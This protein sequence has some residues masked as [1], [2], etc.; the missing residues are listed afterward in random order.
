[1]AGAS[2]SYPYTADGFSDGA[3][4]PAIADAANVAGGS[5]WSQA[6]AGWDDCRWRID[7]DQCYRSNRSPDS[8]IT[9]TLTPTTSVDAVTLHPGLTQGSDHQQHQS[10]FQASASVTQHS[11]LG[12]DHHLLWHGVRYGPSGYG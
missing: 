11:P 2:T 12:S 3:Y 1:M 9:T 8:A 5:E 7:F 6:A 10:V 4:D